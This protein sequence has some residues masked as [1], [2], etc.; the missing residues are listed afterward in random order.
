MCM[1]IVY[2]TQLML[3]GKHK[4]AT[5]SMST[6]SL[7]LTFTLILS[8][9]F[10]TCSRFWEDAVA[11]FLKNFVE[12][13][14]SSCRKNLSARRRGPCEAERKRHRRG[15]SQTH[16]P[17]LTMHTIWQKKKIIQIR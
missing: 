5:V 15:C 12:C 13:P 14:K 3:G 8:T 2:D 1:F 11:K 6:F 4:L 9:C 16:F 7:H 10:C 17:L